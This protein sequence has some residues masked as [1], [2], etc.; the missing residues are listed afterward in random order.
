M[1]I[2]EKEQPDVVVL[3]R[4]RSTARTSVTGSNQL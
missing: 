3:T 2:P 4:R 1:L